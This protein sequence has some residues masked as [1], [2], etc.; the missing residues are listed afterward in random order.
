MHP[1]LYAS[2]IHSRKAQK[3]AEMQTRASGTPVATGGDATL[4]A[5]GC[6]TKYVAAATLTPAEYSRCTTS[7]HHQTFAA[8]SMLLQISDW[9][10]LWGAGQCGDRQIFTVQVDSRLEKDKEQL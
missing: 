1:Y 3:P 10:V 4:S 7:V 2:R 8:G 9:K 6:S 5:P